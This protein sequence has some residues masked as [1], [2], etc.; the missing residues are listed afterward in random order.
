MY[1]NITLHTTDFQ[2]IVCTERALSQGTEPSKCAHSHL[3]ILK[4]FSDRDREEKLWDWMA[5]TSPIQK[6][7]QASLLFLFSKD[8]VPYKLYEQIELLSSSRI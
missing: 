4:Y 7:Q 5:Q 3:T 8:S 6:V 2:R 1:P